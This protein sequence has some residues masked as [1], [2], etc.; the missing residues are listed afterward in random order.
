MTLSEMAPSDLIEVIKLAKDYEP[1][2][3]TRKAKN[4]HDMWCSMDDITSHLILEDMYILD[5]LKQ[6]SLAKCSKEQV[7]AL[8]K[9][10]RVKHMRASNEVKVLEDYIDI[11]QQ[12]IEFLDM[13]YSE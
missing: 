2:H 11:A 4:I 8:M 12:H 7:E 10:L 13:N 1:N 5:E 3:D 9:L 6:A